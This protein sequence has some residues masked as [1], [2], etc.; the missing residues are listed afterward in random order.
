M[1]RVEVQV[2]V[3]VRE[4]VV[5]PG[6]Q[7]RERRVRGLQRGIGLVLG[8]PG[9]VLLERHHRRGRRVRA[10]A[11]GLTR[12]L[13]D[14]VTEVDH[15]VDVLFDEVL[16]G[17][18]VAVRVVLAG[19]VGEVQPARHRRVP[20]RGP[21]VPDRADLALGL[22]AVPVVALRPQARDFGVDR[23]HL[24][25]ADARVAAMDDPAEARVGGH[26]EADPVALDP[27]PAAVERVG[28]QA[29][30]QHD[31]VGRRLAGGDAE[32]EGIVGEPRPGAGARD[33]GAVED[34]G[35]GASRAQQGPPADACVPI[36]VHCRSVPPSRRRGIPQAG[37]RSPS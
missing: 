6:H 1:V 11:V 25:G 2:G 31:A 4:L 14:V 27:E 24:V 9:P 20:R 26:L 3:V 21:E 7:P 36:A 35:R 33:R 12:A 29:R 18:E 28:R 8:M 19:D 15:E 37:E 13:V 5:V 17:R 23:V 32:L 34:D 22:E 10:H 30:P 16:E